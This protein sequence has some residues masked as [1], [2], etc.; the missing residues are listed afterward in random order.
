VGVDL[1]VKTLAVACDEHGRVL[2][3]WAE[4]KALQHA[5]GALKLANASYPRTK[6][7]SGGRR[8]QHH[9]WARSTP[10][11]LPL[12][13]DML[14][15]VTTELARGYT[16]V[17]IEDLN[18]AGMPQLRSL[19]RYESDAAFGQFRAQ[20]EYKAPWYGTQVVVA[21]RWFPSPKDVL[22][23]RDHQRQPDAVGP[24]LPLRALR[25]G[26]RPGRERRSEPRPL[27]PATTQSPATTGGALTRVPR[28]HPD[29]PGQTRMGRVK[30]RLPPRST[31]G[32]WVGTST[33]PPARPG[34]GR[35]TTKDRLP[36]S[37]V[38]KASR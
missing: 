12:R 21:G 2:H 35:K 22:R 7:D 24:G 36:T 10:G 3:T 16:S 6:R 23:V 25:P 27:H 28:L 14:H 29:G 5:Q 13:D 32:P 38:V 18:V 19:A 34:G 30:S 15:N 1:G 33:R 20:L 8:R 31:K 26:H 4:V 17:T 11:S 9:T 37:G